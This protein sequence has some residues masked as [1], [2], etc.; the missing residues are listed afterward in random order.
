MARD[1]PLPELS[2]SAARRRLGQATEPLERAAGRGD[3][4]RVRAGAYVDSAAWSRQTGLERHLLLI[5]AAQ[6][7]ARRRPVFSHESAAA[8]LDIPLAGGWPVRPHPTSVPTRPRR[9]TGAVIWHTAPLADDE[10][11]SVGGLLVTSPIRTLLDLGRRSFASNVISIDHVIA[12]FGRYRCSRE[13]LLEE[14][15]FR[16]PFANAAALEAAA[17]LATGLAQSP[18]ESLSMARFFEGGY[19]LLLQQRP[20]VGSRGTRYFPD[21]HWLDFDAIG[22][23]DGYAKYEDPE[24]LG[25]RSPAEVFRAEKIR[26]DELRA[27]VRAFVRWDWA[28]A[29]H[30]TSL[31]RKLD[32]AGIPRSHRY[33]R[34]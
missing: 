34:R 25:G 16:R 17:K 4:V 30:S 15:G 1:Q 26:E 22:E 19:P 20:F 14:I 5:E 21:F 29:W 32:R 13:H 31:Y 9:S 2:T 10:V 12:R 23:S 11:V 28:D 3:L 8:L 18:G 24:L 27:L 33:P 7:A 6:L